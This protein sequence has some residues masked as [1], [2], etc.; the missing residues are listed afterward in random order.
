MASQY[1]PLHFFRRVPNN[2]LSRYFS[3]RNLSLGV[4]WQKLKPTEMQPVLDA[5]EQLEDSQQ[6]EV[7]GEF[8]DINALAGE[9]GVTALVDEAAFH[10]DENFT[11]ALAELEGF[12][13]KV[14][15]VFLEKPLYWRGATM[16]LHADNVSASFWKRRNDLPKLP[17]HVKDSDIAALAR[18]ISGLF[19][20]EGRGKNCKVEPYRRHNREYFF[21]YPED[22]AQLGIEWVSN[23]LKTLAVRGR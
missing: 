21:A 5:F 8:Q 9:G 23:T 1:S 18:A 7:E 17:P 19:R 13:A 22:F 15:W 6:A 16:F 12:H 11:E 10:E 2:L 20:K 14:M 3:E 4:D